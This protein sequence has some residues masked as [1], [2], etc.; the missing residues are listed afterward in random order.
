MQRARRKD[1]A[2]ALVEERARTSTLSE[3]AGTISDAVGTNKAGHM[4]TSKKMMAVYPTKKYRRGGNS[5]HTL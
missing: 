2:T 1:P 4:D 3:L 5:G